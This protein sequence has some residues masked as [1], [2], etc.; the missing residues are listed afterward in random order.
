MPDPLKH[1]RYGGALDWLRES[2]AYV[3]THK[4]WTKDKGV[5]PPYKTRVFL[6]IGWCSGIFNSSSFVMASM[7]FDHQKLDK[8]RYDINNPLDAARFQHNV[9]EF[10]NLVR[11]TVIDELSDRSNNE[12]RQLV[13]EFCGFI[14]DKE[15]WHLA[16]MVVPEFRLSLVE[17]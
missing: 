12:N 17:Q 3:I 4:K 2:Q 1:F 8:A 6:I 11:N 7:I 13:D 10:M 9:M 5:L 14:D 16:Q 15:V